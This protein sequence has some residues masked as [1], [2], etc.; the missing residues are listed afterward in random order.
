MSNKGKITRLL[1]AALLSGIL[2]Y[3]IAG[4]FNEQG[5]S[6]I[7]GGEPSA[8]S[9]TYKLNPYIWDMDSADEI[10]VVSENIS[11]IIF[12]KSRFHFYFHETGYISPNQEKVSVNIDRNSFL[13]MAFWA[14]SKGLLNVRFTKKGI[15]D[16]PESYVSEALIY[17]RFGNV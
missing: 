13:N 9:D 1:F 2:V 14:N 11:N 6:G 5:I 8:D 12:H 7:F 10:S 3:L 16:N 17:E 4:Y 15:G